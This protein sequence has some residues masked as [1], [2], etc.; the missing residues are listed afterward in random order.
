MRITR[1]QTADNRN[2]VVETAEKMFREKGFAGVAVA[3]FMRAAGLT[4]GGF[5]NHFDSK[6]ELEAEAVRLACAHST[7][8]VAKIAAIE[9]ADR[10][11]QAMDRFIQGYL[12]PEIRDEKS[13]RCSMV[14]YGADM[15][16]QSD[17]ARTAYADGLEAYIERFAHALT[18]QGGDPADHRAEAIRTF[19]SMVGAL[20]LARGSRDNEALSDEILAVMRNAL[21]RR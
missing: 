3:D 20:Y 17:D 8:R 2:K 14:A 21:S 9:S 7:A 12:S 11:A 10:R 4:H 13:A 16:R 19:S 5:Y 6:A 15:P 18:P 1:Q